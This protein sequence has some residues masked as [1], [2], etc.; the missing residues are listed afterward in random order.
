[1]NGTAEQEANNGSKNIG[2][3]G[4]LLNLGARTFCAKV[5]SIQRKYCC[6]HIKLGIIKQFV[7]ALTKT[8]NCFK[9]FCKNF[10]HLSKAKLKEG[11]FVGPDIRKIMFDEDLL[12][13][14][15]QVEREA[16]LAFKSVVTKFLGNNKDPDYVT[17]VANML[18]KFKV[19]GCLMSLK[20]HFWNLH[21]DFFSLKSCCSE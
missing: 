1:V 18:E 7:K 12:L 21:L 4:H 9:Y 5:L 14:M 3:Q 6:H 8:G 13:T 17:I 20:I 16:W 11:I 19:L 15:T 2:H 10:P